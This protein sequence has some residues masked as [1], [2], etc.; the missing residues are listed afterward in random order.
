[1]SEEQGGDKQTID[2]REALGL[3]FAMGGL[4][5][6]SGDT[7]AGGHFAPPAADIPSSAPDDVYEAIDAVLQRTR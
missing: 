1:M 5:A 6:A 7:Q 2:R 3:M 4:L